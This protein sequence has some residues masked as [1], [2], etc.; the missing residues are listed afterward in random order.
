MTSNEYFL[1]TM[2]TEIDNLT[3]RVTLAKERVAQAAG[4]LT[5]SDKYVV[6]NANAV[7]GSARELAEAAAQLEQT[8]W[9]V[10]HLEDAI[11]FTNG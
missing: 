2:A 1:K 4:E 11:A 5:R 6:S 10:K 8:K 9:I 7:A 3:H